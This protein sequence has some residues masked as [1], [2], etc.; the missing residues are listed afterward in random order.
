MKQLIKIPA[1]F[2]KQH[3]LIFDYER[4]DL[5]RVDYVSIEDKNGTNKRTG[6]MREPKNVHVSYGEEA[7]SADN[8][9]PYQEVTIQIDNS[10]IPVVEPEH[11]GYR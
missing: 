9:D 2:L 3:D 7:M 11:I 6:L 10:V 5:Q 1:I 4:R 8:F